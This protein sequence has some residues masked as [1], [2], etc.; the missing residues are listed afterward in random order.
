MADLT[1]LKNLYDIT[2]REE[3]EA[4]ENGHYTAAKAIGR[5]KYEIKQFVQQEEQRQKGG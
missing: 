3:R 2:K 5:I 1:D 4:L